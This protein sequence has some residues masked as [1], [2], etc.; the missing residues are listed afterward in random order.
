[1]KYIAMLH[2]ENWPAWTDFIQSVVKEN[3]TWFAVS[4]FCT[5]G[6]F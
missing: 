6:Q 2:P 5:V 4:D 3:N 1:M